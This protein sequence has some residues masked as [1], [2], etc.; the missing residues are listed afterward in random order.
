MK[1]GVIFPVV[2][3]CQFLVLIA[4]FV[5]FDRLVQIEYDQYYA[6][7][8]ADGKPAGFFWRPSGVSYPDGSD[9]PSPVGRLVC[10]LLWL[11]TTPKWVR[12]NAMA[13]RRLRQFR[14]CVLVWNVGFLTAL[15]A[16]LL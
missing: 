1:S 11:F 3:F 9:A 6:Q 8:S 12:G 14:L 2:L 13:A 10:G 16:G 5:S 4:A 15:S 7:W